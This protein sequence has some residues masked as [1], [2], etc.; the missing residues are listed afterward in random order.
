MQIREEFIE[1]MM[2]CEWLQRCGM[3]DEFSFEVE[4]VKKKKAEKLIKSIKWE[5]LCLDRKGDFTVYLTLNH[6]EERKLWNKMVEKIKENY[7]PQIREKI[8]Q[9]LLINELTPRILNDISFNIIILF[10]LEYYSEF[11]SSEFYENMMEIYLSGHLPCGWEGE[12]PEGKF[13]VY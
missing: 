12:Y 8:N 7:M 5:N 4:Y 10:M 6:R 13:L 1:K 11:Y 3:I 9:Y 2:E